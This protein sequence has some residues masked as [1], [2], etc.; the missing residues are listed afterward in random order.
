MGCL[1]KYAVVSVIEIFIFVFTLFGFKQ[2][3]CVQIMPTS[4][5]Y[6]SLRF[7]GHGSLSLVAFNRKLNL[8]C[9]ILQMSS[10]DMEVLMLQSGDFVHH[11]GL[12][13]L[14]G[15]LRPEMLRCSPAQAS[16]TGLHSP[17]LFLALQTR[18]FMIYLGVHLPFA[19]CAD[20]AFLTPCER[21]LSSL[22][23]TR[24]KS[25]PACTTG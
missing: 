7:R 4:S 3:Y 22:A 19:A 21:V 6:H 16:T 15:S 12:L 2:F 9:G 11:Y 10:R 1:M 14:L 8:D 24:G 20:G 17:H 18:D 23:P 5:P 13:L 25:F